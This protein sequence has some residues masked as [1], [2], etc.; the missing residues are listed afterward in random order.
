MTDHVSRKVLLVDDSDDFRTLVV[1]FFDLL[2]PDDE[3]IEYDLSQGP[4]SDLFVWEQYDLL[5]LDYNLGEGDNG[6]D[7]L[8]R[9]QRSGEFPPT[10][11]LTGEGNE[12][13]AVKALQFGAQ[14]YLR[15]QGLTKTHLKESIAG[16]LEKH[17]QVSEM[18]NTIGLSNNIFNK[19][20][21]LSKL[22]G[23]GQR[24]LTILIEIDDFQ[25][26]R[27][28][29]GM[30][31]S[32]RVGA[33]VSSAVSSLLG[34]VRIRH[35]IIRIGDSSI[36]GI[37]SDYSRDDRGKELAET[38]IRELNSSPYSENNSRIEFTVSIGLVS[39]DQSSI[40]VETVLKRLDDAC[41]KSRN[42]AGNSWHI[43]DAPEDI[44]AAQD[45]ALKKQ[46]ISAFRENRVVPNYQPLI[47]IAETMTG[48]DAL[49][50]IRISLLADDNSYISPLEFMPTIRK[51]GL[52]RS[53]DRWV[54]QRAL[55]ML[56]TLREQSPDHQQAIMVTLTEDSLIDKDLPQWLKQL[57]DKPET[58]D[59]MKS[60]IFK[61]PAQKFL[62]HEQK[63]LFL[64]RHIRESLGVALALD[65]VTDATRFS[66]SIK[67]LK[68]DYIMFSPR[69]DGK[70]LISVEEISRIVS[71]AHENNALAVANKLECNEDLTRMIMAGVDFVS[72]HFIQAPQEDIIFTE[73]HEL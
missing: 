33:F 64:M 51:N 70:E 60:L 52:K 41:L 29:Y 37:I 16:V 48:L 28:N 19:S 39:N 63:A 24:D 38:I 32:D 44:S 1:R 18:I 68:L 40:S 71:L 35:S 66:T 23:I 50:M 59:L 53:L 2:F 54:I 4:P 21:F 14:D 22:E 73:E 7:W 56:M 3:I 5:L 8:R 49:Y 34:Q 10:L 20:K 67:I 26:L 58:G 62:L 69:I 72:G 17:E 57:R 11:M 25:N 42:K 12:E 27:D 13:I 31:T 61:M 6:L 36:A 65:N 47:K 9:Y 45:Q 55:K 46:I 30:M 43:F 15:K